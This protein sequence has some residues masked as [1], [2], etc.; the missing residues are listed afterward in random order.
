MNF[1]I[2]PRTKKQRATAAMNDFYYWL[3]RMGN[4]HMA[5]TERMNEAF[6][7]VYQSNLIEEK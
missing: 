2:K 3:L 1:I 5:D 4:V 7:K 6:Q